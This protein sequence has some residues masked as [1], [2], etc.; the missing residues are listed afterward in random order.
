MVNDQNQNQN[1]YVIHP[2]SPGTI[3]Q[4]DGLID[5]WMDGQTDGLGMDGLTVKQIDR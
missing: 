3:I 1:H 2:H 5:R 4:I